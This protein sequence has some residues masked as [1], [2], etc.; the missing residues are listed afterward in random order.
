HPPLRDHRDRQR[1]LALQEPLS[2]LKPTS[3]T[4]AP[5]RAA[6]PRPAPPGRALTAV[7]E[8]GVKIGRRSRVSFARRL[9]KCDF[10]DY[11]SRCSPQYQR[12]LQPHTTG[13]QAK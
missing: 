12:V 3:L 10:L 7:R 1:I 9:T 8:K 13:G 5:D 4:N 2:K 11:F 6:Q